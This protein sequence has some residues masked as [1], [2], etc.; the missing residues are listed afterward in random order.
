MF[1]LGTIIKTKQIFKITPKKASNKPQKKWRLWQ[2]KLWKRRHREEG[3]YSASAFTLGI[4]PNSGLRV[5]G[6]E[7][8]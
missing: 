5:R 8:A 1:L 3:W 7:S 6:W 4:F 2:T